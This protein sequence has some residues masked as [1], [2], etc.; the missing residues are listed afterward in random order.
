MDLAEQE[1]MRRIDTGVFADGDRIVI[2]RLAADLGISSVP[3]R[4]ALAR[5]HTLKLLRREPN[6][7][8]SVAPAP[9]PSELSDLFDVR[10]AF[11]IGCLEL[12]VNPKSHPS[13][14]EMIEINQT[15]ADRKFPRTMDGYRD[16][17][18][19]NHSFHRALVSLSD[20]VL[21]V[22]SYDQL[23]YHQRVSRAI[24]ERGVEEI[25]QIVQEHNGVI[26]ALQDE[27]IESARL[28]L[29]AHIT[30]GRDRYLE[31]S[32]KS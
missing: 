6:R 29:R 27:N 24:S 4:E 1:M 11:E 16:F 8:Y 14:A 25:N 26:Q 30:G 12:I 28:R 15:I 17:A 20:N 22:E 10:L 13:L 31:S 19:L 2:D 23:G 7:G 9:G 18:Q 21:L 32:L 5:L 3:M